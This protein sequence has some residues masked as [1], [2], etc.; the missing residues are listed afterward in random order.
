VVADPVR[1]VD[2]PAT[3]Q[4]L[5]RWFPDNA[6]CLE[7]LG[8]LR[9]EDGFVC[10]ACGGERFWRTGAGLW[11]CR[12][13]Q[14]RTSVTA[15]TIFHRTRTPMSTWFAAIWFV[16]SQ[17]N[18]MSAQG[19]QRVLG[20][21]SYETAWAWLHKLRRA[22]VRPDRDRLSG[23]VEVDETMVG[24]VSPGMFGAATGKVPVMIAVER[25]NHRGAH[26]LGRVRLAVADRPGS[27]ALV[28]WAAAVIEPGSTIKT[29]GAPVLRRLADR[30]F[31][32]QATAAYSAADQSSVLPGVHLVASLLKRW[33]IGTLHYRV[34]QQHLPYYLDE[35]TFRFNR[36]T[37]RSRGLL[38]YRLLQQAVNTDP[39]PLHELLRPKQGSWDDFT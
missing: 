17:K 3:Y 10:P 36:R 35:Y 39:H 28:D 7:Y 15:G 30:G 34:E 20:F 24:G 18:G 9:W 32:H 14:R 23:T 13:C 6:A 31:T 27:L 8:R 22:M 33:L 25:N 38:F 1:G 29:D 19:L 21:G 4:Q 16:T 2:Y 12:A 37:A 5:L 26:R 11:M